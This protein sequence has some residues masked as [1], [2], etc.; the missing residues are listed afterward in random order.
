MN[1]FNLEIK[2]KEHPKQTTLLNCGRE[3]RNRALK[4]MQL[5]SLAFYSKTFIFSF[6]AYVKIEYWI[7]GSKIV[8][9]LISYVLVA[10]SP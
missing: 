3:R 9:M 8:L 2:K 7:I 6:S 5:F 1:E 4:T 10:I